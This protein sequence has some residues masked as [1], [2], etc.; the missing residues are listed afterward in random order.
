MTLYKVDEYAAFSQWLFIWIFSYA[1]YFARQISYFINDCNLQG[2]ITIIFL[3]GAE[4][5]I[6]FS[7]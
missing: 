2:D 3:T 5:V 7:E 4:P 1:S 6:G